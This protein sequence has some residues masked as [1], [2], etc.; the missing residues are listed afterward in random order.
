MVST[1]YQF[2]EH[3]L[4]AH[5]LNGPAWLRSNT[6]SKRINSCCSTSIF[7]SWE[8]QLIRGGSATANI[9]DNEILV[10]T[11]PSNWIYSFYFDGADESWYDAI[12][13]R[14]IMSISSSKQSTSHIFEA[15]TAQGTL[16][17][18][19]I[20]NEI[21]AQ[22]TLAEHQL[23]V[24][25]LNNIEKYT[26]SSNSILANRVS[27]VHGPNPMKLPKWN[28]YKVQHF[29]NICYF[30]RIL[31]GIGNKINCCCSPKPH[32]K[33]WCFGRRRRCKRVR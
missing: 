13:H 8:T 3:W 33:F 23:N 10:T 24:Y 17:Q 6:L 20:I 22:N 4:A 21:R 16:T 29:G 11:M 31:F 18:T 19:A 30:I 12:N 7:P 15:S 26:I 25:I 27:R 5:R 2:T 14:I 1:A 28:V 32:R 9:E